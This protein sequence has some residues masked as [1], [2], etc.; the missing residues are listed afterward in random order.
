[1][2]WVNIYA[3]GD[4]IAG[5]LN[6]YGP[7]ADEGVDPADGPVIINARDP[8]VVTPLAAHVQYWENDRIFDEIVAS[9]NLVGRV[10]NLG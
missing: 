10:R 2:R 3:P 8:H 4:L 5:E 9:L 6:H 7:S 1:M